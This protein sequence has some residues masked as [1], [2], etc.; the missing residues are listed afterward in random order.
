MQLYKYEGKTHTIFGTTVVALFVLQPFIGFF[1]H[2]QFKKTGG[3]TP[4]SYVHIWY[5]RSI[6]ILAVVNGG[7]G[8]K[9]AGNTKGGEIA[10]GVV[11]GVVALLY[12]A[13]VLTKRKSKAWG[14]GKSSKTGSPEPDMGENRVA[15]QP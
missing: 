5:G 10:Y 1:H 12:T 11:A 14:F 15:G 13:A 3:R 4:A 8:L 6:M 9:L 2:H 7:L